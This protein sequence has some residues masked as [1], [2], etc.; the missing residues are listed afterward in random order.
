M[1]FLQN[2]ADSHKGKLKRNQKLYTFLWGMPLYRKTLYCLNVRTGQY[3]ER[4]GLTGTAAASRR[5]DMIRS[6]WRYGCTY[7]EYDLYGFSAL[8]HRARMEYIGDCCRK[9][10]Y[11]QLNSME[12]SDCLR[13]KR[14]AYEEFG[15]YYGRQASVYHISDGFG[16]FCEIVKSYGIVMVKP[17]TASGGYGIMKA[18][19]ADPESLD[20][21]FK[22]L[23]EICPT[24]EIII[25]EYVRQA[26]ELAALH[27]SSLN[28]ARIITVVDRKGVPHI[29]GTLFRIG[30]DGTV[31]DNGASGGILC[32]LSEDGTILKSM[33]KKNNRFYTHH[34]NT[35]H[36]LVGFTIPRW[37]EAKALAKELALKKPGIRYCGWDLALTDRGW[38]MIEGNEG[39]ELAGIQIFSGGCKSRLTKYL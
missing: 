22:K 2:F 17:A 8:D 27:P 35:D 32:A 29:L 19:A 25:E 34:P 16:R 10:Y 6:L 33:D 30:K 24:D 28:T 4:S 7:A 1:S 31:V 39:A 5:A 11:A 21:C 9:K 3:L 15:A 38:I 23:T 26:P 18:D 20:Q 37:D 12:E 36:P 13:N 14:L